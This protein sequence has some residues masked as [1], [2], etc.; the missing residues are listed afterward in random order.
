[1]SNMQAKTGTH[2]EANALSGYMKTQGGKTVVFSIM[3]NSHLPGS[4]A[5]THA[6]D[7]IAEAI[8][9]AE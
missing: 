2:S 7:K 3:V 6:I 4:E 8:W 9:S 5:E 1:M